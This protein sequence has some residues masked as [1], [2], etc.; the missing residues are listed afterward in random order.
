M[1]ERSRRLFGPGRTNC[2]LFFM[3]FVLAVV[4]LSDTEG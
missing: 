2:A 3:E 4:T 1:R